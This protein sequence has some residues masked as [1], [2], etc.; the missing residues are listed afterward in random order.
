MKLSSQFT[1]ETPTEIVLKKKR[2]IF[3]K[4]NCLRN[5]QRICRR[6]NHRSC[7]EHSKIHRNSYKNC[8]NNF[9]WEKM[10]IEKFLK[11]FRNIFSKELLALLPEETPNDFQ[12]TMPEKLH[13]ATFFFAQL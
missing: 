10:P 7:R 4:K 13:L 6:N 8:Q 11:I 2:D 9:L 12:K 1:N 3:R 5:S